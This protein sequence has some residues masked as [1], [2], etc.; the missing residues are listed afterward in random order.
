MDL[1]LKE[2][3][4]EEEFRFEIYA[5]LK[6][7]SFLVILDEES[8][9]WS[10][11]SFLMILDD[12]WS[13]GE[14]ILK[15]LTGFSDWENWKFVISRRDRCPPKN[16]RQSDMITVSSKEWKPIIWQGLNHWDMNKIGKYPFYIK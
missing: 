2:F 7:K 9:F 11:Q 3:A 1:D 8:T 12:V 10:N 15:Q 5:F 14:Q 13:G 6:D 4:T 16:E